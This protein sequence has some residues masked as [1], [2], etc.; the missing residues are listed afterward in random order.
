MTRRRLTQEERKQETRQL[1]LESAAKTFA[2]LGFHGASVDKIAEFAGF[3]KGAVY[4]HF[5]SKEELFLAILEQQMKLHVHTIHKIISQQPS[6]EHFH[7]TMNRYFHS[8][9]QQTRTWSM[10][11]ME[12]LLYA[13]REESVRQKWSS[14]ILESAEQLSKTIEEMM[15][16]E[17][18]E[19]SLSAEEMAWTLLSLENGMAIF[20]SIVEN[21]A[22]PDL[23]GKALQSMLQPPRQEE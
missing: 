16:K 4:A 6:L 2:Q 1:L 13:M 9:R 10:L 18:C 22:P 21:A 8:A 11:N 14:M 19:A 7:E 15:A 17:H 20:S 23:F 3:S 12:F 5:Q